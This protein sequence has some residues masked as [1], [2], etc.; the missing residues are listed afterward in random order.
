[1]GTL[2]FSRNRG[3]SIFS[4][5]FI[6]CQFPA[7]KKSYYYVVETITLGLLYMVFN[8][9]LKITSMLFRTKFQHFPL[10]FLRL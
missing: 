3:R 5:S 6:M 4:V 10:D 7:L 8:A 1:M 9:L 2:I